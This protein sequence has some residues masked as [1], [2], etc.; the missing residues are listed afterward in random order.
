MS[1]NSGADP[2]H[3]PTCLNVN[4]GEGLID[5]RP[6][7]RCVYD[8]CALPALCKMVGKQ[9]CGENCKKR[10][11]SYEALDA[12]A[13]RS[14]GGHICTGWANITVTIQVSSSELSCL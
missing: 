2:H 10:S 9:E 4:Q 7:L 14:Y 11:E 12:K 1:K 13:T 8:C 5:I 6:V 3:I